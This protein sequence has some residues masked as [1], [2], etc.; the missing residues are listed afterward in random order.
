MV[1]VQNQVYTAESRV[2]SNLPSHH[3]DVPISLQRLRVGA[4]FCAALQQRLEPCAHVNK[5]RAF[6]Q[7][8]GHDGCA[9][10]EPF[11]VLVVAVARVRLDLFFGKCWVC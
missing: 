4:V 7:A 5:S 8:C 1:Y 2:H 3:P 11:C 9:S 10:D 6:S